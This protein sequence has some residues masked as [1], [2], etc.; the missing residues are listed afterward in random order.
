MNK[1]N[2]LHSIRTE[3]LSRK[4]LHLPKE[5]KL[6]KDSGKYDEV[7]ESHLRDT[8]VN[9][10]QYADPWQGNPRTYDP[11]GNYLCGECN[12]Y[13]PNACTAVAGDISSNRGSC[14]HWE[15]L[16]KGDSELLFADKISKAFAAYGETTA[17]G[18]GCH[19]CEYGTKALAVDSHG[20]SLFCGQGAF[21]VWPT[22]CC[23]LNDSDKVKSYG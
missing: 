7:L 16:D 10:F 1:A 11:E 15:D 2:F 14:R 5:D 19:R 12:K 13:L 4:L 21:R 22:A 18:F 3:D 20:R 8:F 17:N 23:A 9:M 6:F